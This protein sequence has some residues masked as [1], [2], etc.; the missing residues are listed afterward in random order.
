MCMKYHT[1]AA[2]S[3]PLGMP[4]T[5]YLVAIVSDSVTL[6][7]WQ[8]HAFCMKLTHTFVLQSLLV[9]S[10]ANCSVPYRKYSTCSHG[11]IQY[12]VSEE[13]I[14]VC[15]Y[16]CLSDCLSVPVDGIC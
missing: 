2:F 8:Y 15:S 11:N 6:V 1:T 12:L 4:A 13:S 16:V 10:A 3:V 14:C 5:S 7:T 9:D